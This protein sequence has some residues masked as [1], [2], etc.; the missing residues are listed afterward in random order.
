M[1]INYNPYKDWKELGKTTIST[2]CEEEQ[3]ANCVEMT[4]RALKTDQYHLKTFVATVQRDGMVEKVGWMMLAVLADGEIPCFPSEPQSEK[5]KITKIVVGSLVADKNDTYR[6]IG[7]RLMQVAMEYSYL[8]GCHGEIKLQNALL[9]EHKFNPPHIFYYKIGLRS[10]KDQENQLIESEIENLKNQR[11]C[12]RLP[13]MDLYLPPIEKARW[14]SI[15]RTNPVLL[16][17]NQD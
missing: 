10:L 8:K 5:R 17:T 13:G 6:G 1:I 2:K 3:A 9:L 11:P 14:Q 15:I 12:G 16:K 4:I 7:T